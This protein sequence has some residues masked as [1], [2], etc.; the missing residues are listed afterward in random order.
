MA[1]FCIH[2]HN[3]FTEQGVG[4]GEPLAGE[5][6]CIILVER[7]VHETCSTVGLQNLLYAPFLLGAV[8]GGE[9]LHYQTHWPRLVQ[10]TVGT[11]NSFTGLATEEIGIV[12]APN[13]LTGILI[14]GVIYCHVCQIRKSEQA[15][16]V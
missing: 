9:R 7:L 3:E 6:C 2:I 4:P 15:G 1:L 12:F 8:I 16:G 11:S 13:E 14:D 10:T 5:V